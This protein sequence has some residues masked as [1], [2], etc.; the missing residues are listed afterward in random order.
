MAVALLAAACS[1][2]GHSGGPATTVVPDQ[3]TADRWVPPAITGGAGEANFC[4]ALT[5][6]YRH[7]ADLPRVVSKPVTEDYLSDYVR[8]SPVVVAAAPSPVHASAA[9]YVGATAT[10][11]NQLVRAGI[12]LNHLPPGSLSE[13]STPAVNA[14][15]TTLSGYARTQCHYTIGGAPNA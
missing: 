3:V 1:G 4:L 6:I 12:D 8:F 13:M 10:Y 11:L 2:G 14:A 15:Y 5:S 9:L 7:L